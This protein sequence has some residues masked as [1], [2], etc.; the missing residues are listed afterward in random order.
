MGDRP[1]RIVNYARLREIIEPRA[2]ELLELIKAEI[3]PIDRE[4]QL[5]AGVVLTG[6]GAKLGGFV[7]LAEGILELPVRVGHPMNMESSEEVLPDPSYA[8]VVGLVTYGKRMR[9]LQD[10]QNKGLMGKLWGV[11]RGPGN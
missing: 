6:G 4:N 9:L 8:T 1:A 2:T 11:L 7:A 5:G 10:R 3:E